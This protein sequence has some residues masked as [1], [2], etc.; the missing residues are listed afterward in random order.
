MYMRISVRSTL[1][2]L[3]AAVFI[4]GCRQA[5]SPVIS[6]SGKEVIEFRVL[7]F[8]LQDVTLLEGRFKQA[9][10]LNERIL[11]DYEPD[12]LLAGF[13]REAGLSPKAEIYGGWES[14]TLAGHSLGHYLTACAMMF[15]TTGN[16]E[17]LRRARYIVDELEIVQNAHG[18]GYI[19]AMENGRQVFEEE[20][21]QGIIRSAGFDLNGIWAPFY[22]HHKVLGGLRD[23]YELLDIE[24]AL[25]MALWFSDWI[26][27]IIGH[28][29]DDTRQDMLRCEYGGMN[30]VLADLYGI[31]G[32]EKYLQLSRLFHDNFVLDSLA[33][34]YDILP[35]KHANTNIPKVIGLARRYELTGNPEEKQTS[36]FF[37]DRV[38]Y[39]HTYV[40][41]GNGLREYFGP[42]GQLRDRLE[43][44]TAETCNVY[45][46]LRLTDHL[47]TWDALGETADFYE[48]ALFNHILS[49]QH[50]E[51]G[52]VIYHLSIDMGGRKV[53]QNPFGFTCCVGSGMESHAKFNENIF[54]HN[55]EELFVFQ[56]I[57]AE[58]NWPDKGMRVRQETAYP[59]EQGTTLV[60]SCEDPVDLTLQLRYPQWAEAGMEVFVNGRKTGFRG[61]P[62]S[63][64]GIRRTWRDG[65]RV[66]VKIP[67]TLRLEPMPDD[68]DRVAV[69]YGPVVLAGD[70]GPEGDPAFNEMLYVPVMVTADRNPANWMEAVPGKVNT[71]ATKGIGYPRDVEMKPF[72]Q[73]HERR[74]SIFWDLF[75][76]EAWDAR[77]EEYREEQERIR[78][79]E[80]MTVDFFQPGEMQPERDHNFEG[81][82]TNPYRF[83]DRPARISTNGWFSFDL[84]VDPDSPNALVVEYWRGG[85]RR[86]R[87]FDI[88]VDGVKI[89]TEDI[90][91]VIE[92]RYIDSAYEIP[93]E[94][95]SGKF[96]VHVRFEAHEGRMIG[97]VF[98]VR[99]V[100]TNRQ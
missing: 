55:H 39:H 45:N 51:D 73:T 52:R 99:S 95:T 88:Y 71:F 54:Y 47:F 50:P 37:L 13:R 89:V 91:P 60:F 64:V 98:G 23:A 9:V 67:F 18:D 82:R 75:T 22:T 2:V 86:P 33:L 80:E 1:I 7:P 28:L 46:M 68:D 20:I 41:G 57:A 78:I 44:N 97:P 16:P 3:L 53:Y 62:G 43:P 84:K 69:F 63:F 35:G 72:Y 24:K 96:T 92:N 48:R 94:L 17:F 30:E 42:A 61:E 15:H 85:Y 49:A 10:E 38:V 66:E 8:R 21:K 40:T 26:E 11:L 34:G 58:L 56:Y 87:I 81:E 14:A 36:L 77:E 83:R 76:R 12:R 32:N 29:D 4:S 27:G 90:S 74:F 25:P 65:D 19:G 31:S 5:E 59:E 70:L 93:E 100:K 79:L 6:A